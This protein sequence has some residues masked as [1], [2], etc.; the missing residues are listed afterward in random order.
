MRTLRAAILIACV[1][2]GWQALFWFAGSSALTSPLDTM[3]YLGELLSSPRFYPHLIETGQ[4]FAAALAIAISA[5][6][7]IGFT[8]GLYR[9]A[10]DVGEPVLVAL[11]SI[12]KLTLYPIVLLAFGIG[13]PAKIAFGAIHGIMPIAIFALGA[14]RNLNPVYLKAARAMRLSPSRIAARVLLPAAIPEIFT[15]IRIGFSL[16]LIGTL[17]GEMFA[18]QRGLGYL[19]IQ[20]IGLHNVRMIMALTLLLVV[21]AVTASALLL[22]VDRRL[23]RNMLG[24]SS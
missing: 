1:L 3:A 9:F 16:T 5:G 24:P 23:R 18:S 7:L 17:L 22:A 19:L 10:A 14:V 15:G 11:Y 12:P 21:I 6:I 8:L 2:A 13:M 4:A 20:A